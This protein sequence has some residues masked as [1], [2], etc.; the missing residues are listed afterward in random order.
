MFV[1]W[2]KFEVVTATLRFNSFYV[3]THCDL[4]CQNNILKKNILSIID[5]AK[6]CQ[7]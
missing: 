3:L 6:T 1:L 5:N 7:S 4:L 2:L